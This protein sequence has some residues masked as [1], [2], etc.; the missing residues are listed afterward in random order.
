[1]DG[2]LHMF[3]Q[4]METLSLEFLPKS[5]QSSSPFFKIKNNKHTKTS[6]FS[7]SLSKM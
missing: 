2:M 4:T 1:M 5:K 6:Q 3:L 7:L